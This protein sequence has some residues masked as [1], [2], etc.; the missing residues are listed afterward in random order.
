MKQQIRDFLRDIPT[1]YNGIASIVLFGSFL[2]SFSFRD[3]DVIFVFRENGDVRS[4]RIIAKEFKNTFSLNLHIQ[5]FFSSD[6][7]NLENFLHKA[8]KWDLLYG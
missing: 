3:V 5:L 4:T 1:R 7:K 2:D 8:G 6:N